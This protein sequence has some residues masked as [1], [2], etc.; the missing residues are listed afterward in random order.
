MEMSFISG[1]MCNHACIFRRLITARL[2]FIFLLFLNPVTGII[3][4]QVISTDPDKIAMDYLDLRGEVILQIPVTDPKIINELSKS[5]SI[6]RIEKEFIYAYASRKGFGAVKAMKLDF[7]VVTPPSLKINAGSGNT[8]SSGPD[9]FPG[10]WNDYPSW[11]EY[12]AFMQKLAAT[13]PELCLLDTI[14]FSAGNRVILALKISDNVKED[15]PEP[16]FLYTSTIHGDEP[17]GFVLLLRLADYL[18]NQYGKDLK[19]TALVNNLQIWINPLANPDG[20][21]FPASD[22]IISPKR[23]N[24]ND[25]DLNR[26]Y[27]DPEDGPHPDGE[28]YQPENIDMMQF[29]KLRQFVLSANFH[30]GA[31]VVNYPWDTWAKFH[32]DDEWYRFISRQ[33]AD[34]VHLCNDQYMTDMVNGITNGFAW[35][36]ISGGRQDWVNYFIYG[37]EV[38]IELTEEKIPPP[39]SL[40]WFW[41]YNYRSLLNYMEQSTFGITGTIKD[42]STL[43]PLKARVEIPGHDALNSFVWSD[44]ITGKFYRMLA[45][46]FYN[47]NFSCN[48]YHDTLI[49]VGVGYYNTIN[50]DV[51][52]SPVFPDDISTRRSEIKVVNPFRTCLTISIVTGVAETIHMTIYDAGG[53]KILPAKTITS[54]AG[55]NTVN[56]E[57]AALRPGWYILK[58]AS[59]SISFTSPVLKSE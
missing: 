38:T 56:I 20:T 27:P 30:G 31:E 50:L 45:D 6:D 15:E 25:I 49:S 26:N 36:T 46:G 10:E 24:I 12:I 57:C 51:F 58:I 7:R 48:G 37:R 34:T 11:T 2:F 8:K 4:G 54:F 16:D 13:F 1:S 43:H 14:G 21:Y 40:P 9:Q 39:D 41:E 47:L 3:S 44:S 18:L 22:I 42:R 23:F 59:P 29:M 28:E 32:P 35:Y 52:L 55:E 33:Y 17:L 19:V 5:I 53:R